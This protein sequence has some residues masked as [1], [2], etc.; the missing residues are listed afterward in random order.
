MKINICNIASNLEIILGIFNILSNV[1]NLDANL[2]C[3]S[4]IFCNSIGT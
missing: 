3:Y 4:I 1:S 2:E